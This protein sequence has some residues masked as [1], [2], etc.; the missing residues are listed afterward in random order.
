MPKKH[1]LTFGIPGDTFA[2]FL[3]ERYSSPERLSFLCAESRPYE[4]ALARRVT[5]FVQRGY[6]ITIITDNM[7]GYCLSRRVVGE[8]FLFYQQVNGEYAWCQG[9]TLLVAILAKEFGVPCYLFPA[10]RQVPDSAECLHF[11]GSV[12]VPQGVKCFIPDRDLIPLSHVAK[13]W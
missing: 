9:G 11:A 6:A 1:L 3:E 8:V 13:K 4:S 5:A 12:V 7:I 10:A 2:A